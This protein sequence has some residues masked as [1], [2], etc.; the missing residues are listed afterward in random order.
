MM[1]TRILLPLL[2]L[3]VLLLPGC[4]VKKV[5]YDAA[6]TTIDE[7]DSELNALAEQLGSCEASL[8]Q[9]RGDLDRTGAD[10]AACDDRARKV[11]GERDALVAEVQA[12]R[13]ALLKKGADLTRAT[14]EADLLSQ[15]LE[16]T[17]RAMGEMRTR[18]DA[19]EERNRIYAQLLDRFRAMIDAG[20][21]DVSIE[22]G[23]IVINLKQD[24]LFESGSATVGA[25]G[26]QTLL[27][28][29]AA[30]AELSDRHF[31]VEGHTD[32]VPI[33]TARF[34]SNWELSTAR[35]TS[36]VMILVEGGVA[37]TTVSAAGFGA[38]HP[39]ADNETPEGKALNR[40]IEII[41]VPDLQTLPDPDGV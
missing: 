28:V 1:K 13:E 5:L 14:A 24:I 33:A 38:F 36:V 30:L 31:Q 4:L 29:A 6:L 22:R 32:N 41:M 26:K 2:A 19:A 11:G 34:P 40:R 15:S 39:R 12:L 16:E 7:Q 9:T 17:R 21:L 8:A 25:E 27:E 18:Q 3:S 35:S 10:L 20:T 23:R 37:P